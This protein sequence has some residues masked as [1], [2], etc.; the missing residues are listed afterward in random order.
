MVGIV[1]VSL[2][3]M[4]DQLKEGDHRSRTY[5]YAGLGIIILYLVQFLSKIL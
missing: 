4:E 3:M 1:A 2:N 5:Y